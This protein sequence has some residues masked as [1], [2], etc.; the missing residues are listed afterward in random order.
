M[1][2]ASPSAGV[3]WGLL[4][5]GYRA[6]LA[7]EV[8]PLAARERRHVVVGADAG[9]RVREVEGGRLVPGRRYLAA[10]LLGADHALDVRLERDEVPD[11]PGPQRGEQPGRGDRDRPGGRR[12]DGGLAGGQQGG[13]PGVDQAEQRC[14]GR[15]R[16]DRVA[17]DDPAALGG[18]VGQLIGGESHGPTIDPGQPVRAARRIRMDDARHTPGRP[19]PDPPGSR[20]VC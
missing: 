16:V 13:P 1:I 11:R 5:P 7:L 4:R 6:H 3:R 20:V 18:A 12:V 15:Q 9:V 2:A 14:P 17:R 19:S 10:A 8:E